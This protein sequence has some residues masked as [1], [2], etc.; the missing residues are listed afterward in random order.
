MRERGLD[1]ACSEI[2][3]RKYRIIEHY[4][5]NHV[6][7]NNVRVVFAELTPKMC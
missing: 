2:K 5:Y 4:V 1:N 7:T 6:H 3:R